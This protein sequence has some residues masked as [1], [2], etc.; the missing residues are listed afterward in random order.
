MKKRMASKDFNISDLPSNR[1]EVF[2]DCLKNRYKYLLF[3]G[4]I[5]FL[6]I[7]PLIVI[8]FLKS[9]YLGILVENFRNGAMSENEYSQATLIQVLMFDSFVILSSFIASIGISGATRVIRQVGWIEPVFFFKDFSDGIK[10]NYKY[11]SFHLFILST[12]Y[13]ISDLSTYSDLGIMFI[14]YIPMGIFIFVAI[15]M[16]LYNIA[17]ANIYNISLLESLKN[18]F[19]FLIRSVHISLLFSL[20]ILGVMLL[21]LIP[22]IIIVMMIYIILVIFVLP[23]YYLLWFLYSSYMFDKFI[24]INNYPEIVDKGITR[25]GIK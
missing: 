22:N 6:T 24:N 13:M 7:I 3:S 1:K 12:I 25:K 17:E 15:P 2:F 9:I 16:V 19:L 5:L 20:G 18:S 14:N 21:R 10:M 4:L 11:I 23:I 8:Y